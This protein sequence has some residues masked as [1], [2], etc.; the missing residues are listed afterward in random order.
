[1]HKWGSKILRVVSLV[2]ILFISFSQRNTYA[3]FISDWTW[4]ID[5]GIILSNNLHGT[6]LE[7]T[8]YDVK[9]LDLVNSSRSDRTTCFGVGWHRLYHAGVDLYLPGQSA[10]NASVKSVANG[11]V[12]FSLTMSH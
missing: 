10:E 8:D 2:M 9:N 7:N 3:S 1:M 6:T 4:P 12:V 11:S 5:G